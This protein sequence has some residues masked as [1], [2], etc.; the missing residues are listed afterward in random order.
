MIEFE[1]LKVRAREEDKMWGVP[2]NWVEGY[3]VHLHEPGTDRDSYRIY[4]GVA[5]AEPEKDGHTFYGDWKEIDPCTIELI[6]G[7]RCSTYE[8][9]RQEI[10]KKLVILENSYNGDL[11]TPATYIAELQSIIYNLALL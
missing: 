11:I 10:I 6:E 7:E 9:N 3:F 1:K 4:T 5:E 8:I 2:G